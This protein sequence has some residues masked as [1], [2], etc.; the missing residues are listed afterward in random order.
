M[1][2]LSVEIENRYPEEKE[3]EM[4]VRQQTVPKRIEIRTLK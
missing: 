1:D 4:M 2:G 3:L